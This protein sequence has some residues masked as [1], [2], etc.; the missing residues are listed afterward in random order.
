MREGLEGCIR[1][2]GVYH[3]GKEAL[4]QGVGRRWMSFTDY[5]QVEIVGSQ[6]KFVNFGAK[7]G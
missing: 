6:Y 1:K 7:K 2:R 4:L 5:S 3:N